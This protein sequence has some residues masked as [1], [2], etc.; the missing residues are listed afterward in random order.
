MLTEPMCTKVYVQLGYRVP[1][2][3]RLALMKCSVFRERP[4]DLIY[5]RLFWG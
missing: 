2:T 1:E 3:T 4:A 5:P